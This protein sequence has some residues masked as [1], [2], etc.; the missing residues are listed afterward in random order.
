MIGEESKATGVSS[1]YP[2]NTKGSLVAG[3]DTIAKWDRSYRRL[4]ATSRGKRI[5]EDILRAVHALITAFVSGGGRHVIDGGPS[6][7]PILSSY[8][9]DSRRNGVGGC[10][11]IGF[12]EGE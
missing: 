5:G 12:G 6:E 2:G 1:A 10:G 9:G 4:D 3:F 11:I 7:S 8:T